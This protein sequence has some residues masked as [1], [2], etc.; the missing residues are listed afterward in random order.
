MKYKA[1]IEEL[2]EEV[3]YRNA[4]LRRA[5]DNSDIRLDKE[6]ADAYKALGEGE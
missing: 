2:E 3:A 6:F 1:R 5:W 4:M